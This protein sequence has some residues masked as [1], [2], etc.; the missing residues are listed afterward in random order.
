ME[1]KIDKFENQLEWENWIG[2]EVVK[3]SGKPFK[4]GEKVGIPKAKVIN[5]NSGKEAFLMGECITNVVDCYQ[6]RL[7]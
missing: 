3:H 6:C 1:T 4:S 7:K 5:P 2:K